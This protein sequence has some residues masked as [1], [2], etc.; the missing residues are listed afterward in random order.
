MKGRNWKFVR[1][2]CKESRPSDRET[3]VALAKSEGLTRRYAL[4]TE[5]LWCSQSA[6]LEFKS[7]RVLA[8]TFV[9]GRRR[10]VA[11]A[12]LNLQA[13]PATRYRNMAE[14]AVKLGV[15]WCVSGNILGA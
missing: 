10:K 2:L 14:G 1:L 5:R 6:D 11:F 13:I 8:R 3:G 12:C 7:L 9:L 15:G 4:P